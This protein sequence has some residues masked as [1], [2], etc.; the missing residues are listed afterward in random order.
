[1]RFCIVTSSTAQSKTGLTHGYGVVEAFA[2][3][4][5]AGLAAFLFF[6]ISFS[7]FF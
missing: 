5:L 7:C 1:M 3:F 2:T 6:S 4:K